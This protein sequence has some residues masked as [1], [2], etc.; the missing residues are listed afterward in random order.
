MLSGVVFA[1]TNTSHE[2]EVLNSACCSWRCLVNG[3][4][5]NQVNEEAGLAGQVD[6]NRDAA[7]VT[8]FPLFRVVQRANRN[9]LVEALGRE[10]IVELVCNRLGVLSCRVVS[11]YVHGAIRKTWWCRV[12]FS[13]MRVPRSNEL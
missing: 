10:N 13:T 2:W 6:V 12:G 4:E 3:F 1:A 11:W 5:G 7:M 9:G 8:W